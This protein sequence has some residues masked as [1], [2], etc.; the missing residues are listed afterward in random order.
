MI[1]TPLNPLL[2][3]EHFMRQALSE[4]EAAFE[5][6]EVPIGAVIV[7]EGEIIGA[8]HNQRETLRDPTAHAEMIAMTQAAEALGDWR[9]EHCMLY[10]TLEPCPMCAGGIV[11]ARIPTVIYGAT[12]P[13]AGACH[14]LY[15]ITDDERLNH[16]AGV[17]GGVLAE[18]SK[19]LLQSFFRQQRALGK[20]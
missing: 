11:Q 4:A 13:K 14:S 2:I 5:E 17:L 8:A 18:E 6:Q 16:R 10:V 1:D 9:L 19:L 12:D 3:H 7:Y 20:K 15:S